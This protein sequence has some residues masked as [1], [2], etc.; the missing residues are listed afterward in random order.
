VKTVRLLITEPRSVVSTSFGP[1]VAE[2][3]CSDDGVVSSPLV[4]GASVVIHR[5]SGCATSIY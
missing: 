5:L 2:T 4:S 3:D 1:T